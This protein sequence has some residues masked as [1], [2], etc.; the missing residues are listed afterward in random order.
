V[1]NS[2]TAF[3]EGLWSVTQVL[4][5]Q[6][7]DLYIVQLLLSSVCLFVEVI[8]GFGLKPLCVCVRARARECWV[9]N[10]SSLFEIL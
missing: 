1:R 10:Y 4:E 9:F 2:S 5:P 3:G 6:L 8:S 7:W